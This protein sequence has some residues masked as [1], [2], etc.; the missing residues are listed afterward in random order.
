MS[1]HA[2]VSLQLFLVVWIFLRSLG[3][4]CYDRWLLCESHKNYFK[5]CC[6]MNSHP[7][8]LF[9]NLFKLNELWPYYQ[10]HINQIIL[11][12]ITLSSLALQVLEDFC[13]NFVDC[14]SILES[15]SPD[16]F[17]LCETNLDDSIDSDNFS[18]RG[19][20]PLIQE[21]SSTHIHGLTVYV[22]EG[23]L[24]PLHLSLENSADSY[25]CFDWLYLTQCPTSFS[26][27]DHILCLCAQFLIPFNLR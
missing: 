11:N 9:F 27:I 4:I 1:M 20:L 24:F 7:T 23:P 3:V 21:D 18:V 15:N 25:L 6:L 2:R 14:E 16:I 19:Y 10:K 12:S 5:D 22:K 8:F 17:A 26:S 13:S